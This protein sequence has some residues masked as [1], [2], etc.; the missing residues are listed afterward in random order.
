M[1]I[2]LKKI[3]E[4]DDDYVPFVIQYFVLD[5]SDDLNNKTKI[6]I[7]DGSYLIRND[8]EH[9]L[10]IGCKIIYTDKFKQLPTE[11]I[12]KICNG[13]TTIFNDREHYFFN[14]IAEH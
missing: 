13:N 5:Y 8:I 2:V 6:P 11:V 7:R 4:Y 9:L 14:S 12:R 10:S 1:Y 3:T